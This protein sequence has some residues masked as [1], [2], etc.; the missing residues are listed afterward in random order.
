MMSIDHLLAVSE[1]YMAASGV[2]AE[3]TVSHRVFG[4]TKKIAMLRAGADIT[5]GRFNAAMQWFV[6]HW[7][8]DA[9]LP[10][11][12]RPYRQPAPAQTQGAA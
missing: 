11:E 2:K 10:E 1:R 8:A 3:T 7:P 4:D 9:D 12:L 5:V 6:Q